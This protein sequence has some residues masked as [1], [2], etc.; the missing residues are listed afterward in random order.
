MRACLATGQIVLAFMVW[1]LTLVGV[2]RGQEPFLTW[3]YHFAWWPYI[4]LGDGLLLLIKGESW[5]W[6]RPREFFRLLLWSVTFWLLFEAFNLYLQNWRYTG[7]M[8]QWWLRWPGYAL[9]FATVLPGILITAQVL[10]ALGAWGRTRGRPRDPGAWQPVSLILGTAFL[11]LPLIFP[12]YAFPLIWLSFI[13]LLDPIC[14]VL[15]GPSLI[16]RWV[17]GERQEILC[18]LSAGLICGLWWEMWNFAARAKWVY[19]LPILNSWKVFEM[20]LLGYLGFLPF[21][22][23]CAIIYNFFKTLDSQ[24]L[25]TPRRQHYAWLLHGAFWLIMFTALD[26]WT[27][28]AYR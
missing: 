13:F 28:I 15:G 26:T 2:W 11:V 24:V 23:E 1:G 3:I 25:I 10:A 5:L 6:D 22:L 16:A 20:P 4:L 7:L 21:A 18:L 17:Q 12:R 8:P 9:A 19:T 14:Q 27:V